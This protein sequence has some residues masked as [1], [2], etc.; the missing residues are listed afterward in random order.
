M[1]QYDATTAHA[2]GCVEILPY[3]RY[4]NIV[5]DI[6]VRY[7]DRMQLFMYRFV[8]EFASPSYVARHVC[9]MFKDYEVYRLDNR[10]NIF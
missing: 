9:S 3:Q 7:T 8:D 2:V 6:S 5:Q 10:V 1:G 4:G